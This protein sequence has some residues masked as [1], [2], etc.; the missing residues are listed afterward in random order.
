MTVTL[1]IVKYFSEKAKFF[2][3]SFKMEKERERQRENTNNNNEN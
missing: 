1:E 2:Y 3:I